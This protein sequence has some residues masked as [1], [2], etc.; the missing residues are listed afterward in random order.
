VIELKKP[1]PPASAE[2]F[3]E[4]EGRLAERGHRIPPSYREFL[5]EQD[6][7]RPVK[8]VFRF[9]QHDRE[10]SSRV[11]AFL[12]VEPAA[13][14]DLVGVVGRVGDIPP[15][16]LPI[17]TDEFGNFVCIDTRDDRDGPVLFWD[18]EEG[19]DDDDVDF[20]NLYEIAPDLQ[21]FLDG[22]TEAP[23]LDFEP[24]VLSTAKGWRRLFSRR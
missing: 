18:H 21:T 3:A 14:G 24:V 11:A 10:Q 9:E 8:N 22:L 7:G 5:A 2:A 1:R 19:F 4:T 23:P 15:G 16:I 13:D 20:S 12:G 17:A 6:G